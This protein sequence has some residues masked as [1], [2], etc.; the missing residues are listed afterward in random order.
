MIQWEQLPWLQCPVK[1]RKQ[2]VFQFL[3]VKT[4]ADSSVPK[5]CCC[6]HSMHCNHCARYVG[7]T[8]CIEI[9]VHVKDPTFTFR[10]KKACGLVAWKH[11][12]NECTA[13]TT[14]AAHAKDPM[15]TVL[16][17]INYS[18]PNG[19]WIWKHTDNAELLQNNQNH[20]CRRFYWEKKNDK[21]IMFYRTSDAAVLVAENRLRCCNGDAHCRLFETALLRLGVA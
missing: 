6:V 10:Q 20:D 4:C 15:F 18:K 2:T 11:T 12:N 7:C 9:I 19:R 16:I 5:Y 8:A 17:I 1:T 14:T 13:R 21:E 3:V